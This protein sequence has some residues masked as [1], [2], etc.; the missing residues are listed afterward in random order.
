M[1]L[2]TTGT[3]PYR[4]QSTG[5]TALVSVIFRNEIG[6]L[7]R[8][9]EGA[10]ISLQNSLQSACPI[11][12]YRR[13]RSSRRLSG[14]MSRPMPTDTGSPSRMRGA[15]CTAER[16]RTVPTPLAVVGAA[17][18]ARGRCPQARFWHGQPL[19]QR[20]GERRPR[21]RTQ[22]QENPRLVWTSPGRRPGLCWR[23]SSGVWRFAR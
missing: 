7:W 13:S 22:A 14:L 21:R 18:L 8:R 4:P 20:V 10:L 11:V 5:A 19:P 15:A 6:M 17:V 12:A 16:W 9:I 23:K 1:G 3:R 2:A